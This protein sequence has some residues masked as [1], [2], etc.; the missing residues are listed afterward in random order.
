LETIWFILIT[1]LIAG[2]AILDGFDLGVG[3][4]YLWVARDE[5]ERDQV[6]N[7]IGPL[8]DGN[9]VWLIAAAGTLFFAFP[10]AYA[11]AFSSFYLIFFMILWVLLLRGLAI[12]L[13]S[14]INNPLWHSFWDFIFSFA[15]LTLSGLLGLVIGNLLRGVPLLDQ[16]RYTL[17]LWTRFL[18]SGSVGIVDWYTL[19]VGGLAIIAFTVQGAS[20]L[21]LKTEGELQRRARRV[22]D[23]CVWALIL[24][25][26]IVFP[27]T[28]WIQPIYS[29]HFLTRPLGLIFPILTVAALLGL[30]IFNL[31][32]STKWIFAFSSLLILAMLATAMFGLYPNLLLASA[33]LS[34]S[35]TIYNSATNTYGLRVGLMWFG[36]GF[37]LLLAYV[38]FIYRAY[39]GKVPTAQKGEY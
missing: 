39:W 2:Y 13:R 1:I 20:Y 11:A 3:S 29:E 24:F 28:L 19:L 26:V 22:I 16:G 25:V 8:W 31:R 21:V 18:P 37:T 27:V 14:Q 17:P 7:S 5:K 4:V 23:R 30:M 6:R 10:K 9:E 34:N 12:E 35:L 36:V 32:N 15:S 38:V 33:N